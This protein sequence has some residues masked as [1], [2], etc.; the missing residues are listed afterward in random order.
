MLNL[1]SSGSQDQYLINAFMEMGN[2][3]QSMALVHQK[4]YQSK[5]LSSISL[6]EYI[7]DLVNLLSLSYNISPERI[8]F[9]FDM[10]DIHIP[11]DI[12]IPCGLILNELVTNS[13]KHAFPDGRKGFVTILL[14]NE[15]GSKKNR[16]EVSDNG[17]GLPEGVDLKARAGMG[18]KTVIGLAEMQIKGEISYETL[19]GV[20]FSICFAE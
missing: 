19:G 2:R 4:L 15:A 17:I 16:L 9:N 6:K 12:A 18:I 14:K 13:L 11:V 8:T 1:Y 10:D 20:R 7:L 5:N 3:I